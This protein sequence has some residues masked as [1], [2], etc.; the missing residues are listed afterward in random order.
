MFIGRTANLTVP[1][2]QRTNCQYRNKCWLGCPFGSY[3]STQSSTLPAAMKTVN[4]TLRSWSIV[5]KILYDKDKKR[6]IGVEVL[7]S[8]TN[9][10]YQYFS[11]IVFL[12]A[13]TLNSAWVLMNSATEIWP[14]GL[15]TSSGELGHNLMDHQYGA[16]ASGR[17]EGYEDKYYYGRRPNGIYIPRYRN[18]ME[19]KEI[20]FGVLVTRVLPAGKDGQAK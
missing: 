20:I 13:S 7:D 18:L 1:H 15:G 16:G 3:F 9:K 2:N 6:A 11:K 5:A 14:E 19:R 12:N 10:T 8:E 4:L 17:V